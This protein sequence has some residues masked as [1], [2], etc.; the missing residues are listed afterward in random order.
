MNGWR[1]AFFLGGSHARHHW[2]R[3]LTLAGCLGLI[4]W[5]PLGT[6]YLVNAFAEAT[7]ARACATPQVVGAR[8][9]RFDLVLHALYFRGRPPVTVT[10]GEIEKLGADGLAE[11]VPV[12]IGFTARGHPLVGTT[13]DYFSRR[14]LR[15]ESGEL[16]VLLGDCVLGAQVARH[17]GLKSGDRLMSDPQNVFNIAGAYPLNL[18]VRGVLAPAHSADDAAVFVDVKTAWIIE[19][20]GH[21]HDA[22]GAKT[23]SRLL[24]QST[25]GIPAANSALRHFTEITPA[26]LASFHF[27]GDR[28][29]YP[30]SGALVFARDEKS[31]VLLD[32]RF[33][34]R[35]ALQL[36]RPEAV[37]REI[38]GLIFEV[39]RFLELN[40]ILV[41]VV[42]LTLFSLIMALAVRLR[43]RELET[44][45]QLGC[46]RHFIARL[47]LTEVLMLTLAATFLA[48]LL[49]FAM[50]EIGP[51]WLL[52]LITL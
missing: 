26:N 44:L 12:H 27:H 47:V 43:S 22:V 32:G 5:L 51:A 13:L 19:G 37:I 46:S 21:G 7:L 10:Y 3:S 25:D 1:H 18:T 33:P 50:R 15:V 39:K 2:G 8:G 49:T 48:G 16:F 36:V 28:A 9:S 31:A 29:Q 38:L 4:L 14:E 42:M 11:V 30:L 35:A 6:H 34:P 20:I 45:N 40:F 17:L 24:V 52:H 23:D 41:G